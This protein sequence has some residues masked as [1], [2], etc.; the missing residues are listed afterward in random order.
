M[1]KRKYSP[2]NYLINKNYYLFDLKRLKFWKA[3]NHGYTLE[4]DEMKKFTLEA[5]A[6]K[7][8]MNCDLLIVSEESIGLT[9]NTYIKQK[10]IKVI[11]E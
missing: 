6:Q 3:N 7:I 8:F 9:I 2:E 5:A 1:D 4:I 11:V 10:K